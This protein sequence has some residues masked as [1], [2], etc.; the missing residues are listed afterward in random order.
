LHHSACISE[1][2]RR[3][4]QFVYSTAL[5]RRSISRNAAHS[6]SFSSFWYFSKSA[7]KTPFAPSGRWETYYVTLQSLGVQF[8]TE[9]GKNYELKACYCK[10]RSIVS[11]KWKLCDMTHERAKQTSFLSMASLL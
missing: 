9:V 3:T 11:T 8:S 10:K 6:L 5:L 7:T 4:L 1:T 2:G